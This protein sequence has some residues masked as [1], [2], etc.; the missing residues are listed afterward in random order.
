MPTNILKGGSKKKQTGIENHR[1]N[2]RWAS[3]R[4]PKRELKMTLFALDKNINS[5]TIKS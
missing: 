1:E 3:E 2:T 4:F 5:D